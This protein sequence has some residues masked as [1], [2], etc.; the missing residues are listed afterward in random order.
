MKGAY[1]A[2]T[3]AGGCEVCG[4]PEVPASEVHPCAFENGCACWYGEPCAE[5]DLAETLD[6][7]EPD[8]YGPEGD[9]R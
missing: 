2:G 1:D 8:E 7:M 5:L 4:K 9:Y 6:A 3:V